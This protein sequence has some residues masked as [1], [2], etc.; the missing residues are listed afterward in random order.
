MAP[1]GHLDEI[2]TEKPNVL[3]STGLQRV[4]HHLATRAPPPLV[5]HIWPFL[6]PLIIHF[7]PP[8]CCLSN[9]K[10]AIYHCPE[11]LHVL[12]PGW[13]TP[14]PTI[15]LHMAHSSFQ[16]KFRNIPFS[17]KPL[18]SFLPSSLPP[19]PLKSRDPLPQCLQKTADKKQ[20]EEKE[21]ATHSSIHAWKIPWTEEPGGLQPMGSQRVGHDWATS[22]FL[23]LKGIWSTEKD[24]N[25]GRIS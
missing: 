25:Q 24:I 2:Q 3:Q 8:N 17:S 14:C 4:G 16:L 6:Q 18:P 21:R 10:Q 19:Y 15:I 9:D 13:N 22:V 5:W 7:S 1:R 11:S 12:I 23:K 20:D